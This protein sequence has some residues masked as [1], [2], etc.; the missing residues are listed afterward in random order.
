MKSVGRRKY[1]NQIKKV[2]IL[3]NAKITET[4]ESADN[5]AISIFCSAMMSLLCRE[6]VNYIEFE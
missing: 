4:K 3:K 2:E 1:F 6:F 5:S